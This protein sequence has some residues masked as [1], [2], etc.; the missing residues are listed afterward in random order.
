MRIAGPDIVLF[1]VGL[2]L[3]GG[4]GYALVVSGGLGNSATGVYDVRH[5]VSEVEVGNV[6]V[7]SF[8]TVTE[9]FDV[10]LTHVASLTIV[11]QCTDT[12]PGGTFQMQVQVEPPAASGL[13]V[14]PVAGACGSAIEVP[15]E[16][17]PVPADGPLQAGSLEEAQTEAS[18]DANATKAQGTWTVTVNGRRGTGPVPGI[19][20]GNPGGS[21]VMNAQRWTTEVAAST[22]R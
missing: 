22:L 18:A 7:A 9:T 19:P 1:A 14:D 10:N 13:T 4:A 20:A 2:L 11:I 12:V 15:V 17:T 6:P 3:F 21:I 8:Q 16:V 5:D